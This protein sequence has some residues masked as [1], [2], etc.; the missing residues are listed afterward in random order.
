MGNESLDEAA[1]WNLCLYWYSVLIIRYS[2]SVSTSRCNATPKSRQL[3]GDKPGEH[4][5][6]EAYPES[7][8]EVCSPNGCQFGQKTKCVLIVCRFDIY[9]LQFK[10]DGVTRRQ[11]IEGPHPGNWFGVAFITWTDPNNERIEQQGN[12]RQTTFCSFNTV[13][14]TII[15]CY[16]F[17]AFA[18][19]C[20]NIKKVI[21]CFFVFWEMERNGG[22][23]TEITEASI[24]NISLQSNVS[25]T[26][27]RRTYWL[28]LHC[29]KTAECFFGRLK[30]QKQKS[31]TKAN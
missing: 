19:R 29:R 11:T 16:W 15:Q 5:I 10:S 2:S 22:G 28:S 12:G 1:K 24:I 21:K 8:S 26:I 20:E 17:S 4:H 18:S 23:G 7:G 3:P 6:S 25:Q 13:R 9:T 30:E 27:T 31:Q 14:R